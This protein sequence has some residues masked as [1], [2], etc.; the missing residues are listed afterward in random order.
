[1]P[2]SRTPLPTPDFLLG[3]VDF[4]Q[5]RDFSDFSKNAIFLVLA[6]C[7]SF[8]TPCNDGKQKNSSNAKRCILKIAHM[9]VQDPSASDFEEFLLLRPLV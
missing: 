2:A 9:S 6:L 4:Q 7:T 1:M 8:V 3:N 5:Y